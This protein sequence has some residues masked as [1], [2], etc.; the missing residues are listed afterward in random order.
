MAP[1]ARPTV[2]QPLSPHLQIYRWT[3]T[4]AMS[5]FHRITGT[6]LYG[7]TALVA[8][9]LLALASGPI[10]YSY[11]AGFF[12]SVIGR[13]ILFVYTW[14]LMH[15][16]LGGLRHFAWDFG[17]G[18]DREKRLAMSRLTLIGSVALTL[19]IWAV[20]LLVR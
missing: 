7:G 20:A 5:V 6:A 2:A 13:L 10:A 1:T 8:I 18:F 3:W 17:I 9:W 11:V 15:H 19:V 14:I 4:M 16:M 12:G